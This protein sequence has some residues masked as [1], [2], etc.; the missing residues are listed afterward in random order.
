MTAA[1]DLDREIVGDEVFDFDY[2]YS[3]WESNDLAASPASLAYRMDDAA[4][5]NPEP[6]CRP[7]KLVRCR[8][9]PVV[10]QP[11]CRCCRK[12]V[13]PAGYTYVPTVSATAP[14]LAHFLQVMKTAEMS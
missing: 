4:V 13:L 10:L 5:I 14:Q 2:G 12:Q 1:S 7:H 8:T 3:H 6:D 9:G 11:P